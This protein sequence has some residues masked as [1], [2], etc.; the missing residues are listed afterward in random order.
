M[1]RILTYWASAASLGPVCLTTMCLEAI[2]ADD[3][4]A[5][6]HPTEHGLIISVVTSP[7][8]PDQGGSPGERG[9]TF[10][11]RKPPGILGHDL[12][13]GPHSSLGGVSLPTELGLA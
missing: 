10:Q 6:P 12:G 11:A 9:I 13:L 1:E 3:T 5:A 7:F 2:T 4:L 8:V